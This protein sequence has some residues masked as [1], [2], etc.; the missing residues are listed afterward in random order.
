DVLSFLKDKIT[1][2]ELGKELLDEIDSKATQEAVDNAIGEVQNS[3]NESIQQVENDLAQ[4]SSEIKAQV[5]SVNQSLK[6]NI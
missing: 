4:T 2:S 5:D 3:V 1:S 6:E